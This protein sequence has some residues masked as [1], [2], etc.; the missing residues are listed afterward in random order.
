VRF[1]DRTAQQTCYRYLHEQGRT[2]DIRMSH[3]TVALED[4]CSPE[5]DQPVWE[6]GKD[7]PLVLSYRL[8]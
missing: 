3:D 4:E 7:Q 8:M 2:V 6:V 1:I 5:R